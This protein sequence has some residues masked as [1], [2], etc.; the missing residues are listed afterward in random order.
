M[1]PP[2]RLGL[3]FSGDASVQP[4]VQQALR[5]RLAAIFDD[6]EPRSAATRVFNLLLAT[7]IISNVAAVVLESVESIRREHAEAFIW[8]EHFATTVFAVEYLLRVWACVDFKSGLYREPIEGRLRYMRSFFA[9]VDLVAVL[10]AILGL[11][12]ADDLRVL[13]LLRLLRMAKLIRNSTTFGLLWAVVCEEA[14]SIGALLFILIQT[15]VISGALMYMLESEEQPTVFTS[16]PAA[17]WWAIETVTTVGYGD[18]VPMTFEGRLLGGVVSVVGI[19]TLALF[20]GLITIGFLD[21]LRLRRDRKSAPEAGD[22]APSAAL[23]WPPMLDG[24]ASAPAVC[25]HCGHVL[26]APDAGE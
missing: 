22:P 20:S 19:G 21:Q 8:F 4:T 1:V 25:P 26:S 15:V 11:L 16:I 5:R 3:R 13:R 24:V 7:L 18:M 10:P 23:E 17:M 14:R 2:S 12:G 9:L 6:E